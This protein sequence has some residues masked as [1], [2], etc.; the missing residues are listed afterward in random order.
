MTRRLGTLIGASLAFWALVALPSRHVWGD[1]AAICSAVAALLCLVPTAITM[2]WAG[3]A[4]DRAPEQQLVMVLG[5]T[6]AR[7]FWVLAGGLVLYRL[8]PY[9]Q[10]QQGFWVWILVFYLFTLTVEMALV[11]GTRPATDK[12]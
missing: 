5:G 12:Q 7:M 10:E 9:F 4:L 11:L 1:G 6:A 3:W 2:A 8:F